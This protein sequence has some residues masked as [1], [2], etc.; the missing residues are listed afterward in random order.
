MISKHIMQHVLS[1]INQLS[2]RPIVIMCGDKYQQQPI[3]TIDGETT[4]M[5][6]ILEEEDFYSIDKHFHLT[7]QH[8]CED[9][10]LLSILNHLRFYRPSRA[11]LEEIHEGRI[12]C[13]SSIPTDGEIERALSNH[14]NA[15][16][17]TVSRK[18]SNRINTN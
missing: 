17:I 5:S 7:K 15:T 2:L 4:Q 6:S 3:M 16:V 11:L 8:H 12:L 1:T 13:A 10:Y 14:P 9:E 18:A